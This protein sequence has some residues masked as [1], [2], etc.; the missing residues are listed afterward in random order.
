MGL[1][2]RSSSQA[3]SD[4]RK[5][6]G[7]TGCLVLFGLAFGSFGM[8]FFVLFFLWPLWLS[9][10]ARLWVPTPCT[11]EEIRVETHDGDD[12]DTYSVAVRYSFQAPDPALTTGEA[13]LRT[14]T[15][16]RYSF[17]T[18]S[19]SGR[20]A[21]EAA[22]QANPP[23]S[24]RT[25][26][27]DPRDPRRS[28]LERGLTGD[29]WF[30]AI[31]VLFPLIGY[32][33]AIGAWI[34]GRRRRRQEHQLSA[35][36]EVTAA[37]AAH[38]QALLERGLAQSPGCKLLAS[39]LVCAFWNGIVSVFLFAVL[40][41]SFQK[42]DPEWFLLVF[43]IPFELVG[44]GLL[45]W[46]GYNLLAL[47]NPRIRL[48]IEEQALQPGGQVRLSWEIAGSTMRLQHLTITLEGREEATYTRGTN[49]VTDKEVFHR[50]VLFDSDDRLAM[51]QGRCGLAI[52][53][54]MPAGFTA[55][56]N[57][58]RWV[59]VVHGDIPRWPDMQE[60]WELAVTPAPRPLSI[61]PPTVADDRPADDA[62]VAIIPGHAATGQVGGEAA[63]NL[64]APPRLLEL[65]LFWYTSGRGTMDVGIAE[66]QRIDAA[67]GQG[68]RRFAF[69]L[70]TAPQ[71]FAGKL[72]AITWALELVAE[73]GGQVARLELPPLDGT[74]A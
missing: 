66:R 46:V 73:P 25:C 37:P 31:T 1:F 18:G 74:G 5:T 12:G 24:Q 51:Q 57:R 17:A 34:A 13:L 67:E 9:Q 45:A 43:L 55:P 44:L 10:Q 23:G 35:G 62:P 58:L 22:V 39:L 70:P 49:Q 47:A 69:S 27:V 65:R 15:G 6:Q 63:W 29:I 60:E 32:G 59:V 4:Q 7:G 72:V 42:G 71:P 3:L 20:A 33:M 64:P 2:R 11:I 16:D 28:V 21:K 50:S 68:R 52:P 8:V 19:S 61:L 38:P 56:H 41:P 26:W 30:G 54:G 48:R 40:I 14:W 53:A 36:A